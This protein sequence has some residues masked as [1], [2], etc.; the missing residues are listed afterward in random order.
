M[1]RA[2]LLSLGSILIL[3]PGFVLLSTQS[4]SIV[5]AMGA[6]ELLLG[7]AGIYLATRPG[8]RNPAKFVSILPAVFVIILSQGYVSRLSSLATG[9]SSPTVN[10]LTVTVY[11]WEFG[12][13][14]LLAFESANNL[15]SMLGESGYDE[16]EYI[17]Q[18]NH[19]TNFMLLIAAIS[20][21][22]SYLLYLFIVSV[23]RLNI[24]PLFALIFFGVLYLAITR[25]YSFSRRKN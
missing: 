8:I 16:A 1:N 17:E 23:P 11:M 2:V 25:L 20:L 4:G 7:F 18:T 14:S 3:L 9:L 24:N 22:S 21:V 13:C 10:L 5:L 6:A 12:I 19:M 15:T